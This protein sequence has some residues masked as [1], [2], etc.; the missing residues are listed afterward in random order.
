VGGGRRE[1][2]RTVVVSLSSVPHG[3]LCHTGTTPVSGGTGGIGRAAAIRLCEPRHSACSGFA[4]IL[5]RLRG[6][7]LERS[8]TKHGN[9]NRLAAAAGGIEFDRRRRRKVQASCVGAATERRPSPAK[10]WSGMSPGH[11]ASAGRRTA[12]YYRRQRMRYAREPCSSSGPTARRRV[13]SRPVDALRESLAGKAL[14]SRIVS[15]ASGAWPALRSAR[16]YVVHAFRTSGSRQQGN[17]GAR[18]RA[19]QSPRPFKALA[20]T[21]VS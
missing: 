5:A 19:A 15:P 1:P 14:A 21:R 2:C 8:E 10:G 17:I 16:T 9:R 18:P 3:R 7:P 6:G 13:R 11:A 20:R 12:R 4:S